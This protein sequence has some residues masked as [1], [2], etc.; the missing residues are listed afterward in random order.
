MK[1]PSL[2]TT[3]YSTYDF[4]R[5]GGGCPSIIINGATG[6]RKGSFFCL[7]ALSDTVFATGTVNSKDVGVPN[8]A[9]M[10]SDGYAG[11]TVKAGVYVF[12]DFSAV[13]LTS[14]AVQAFTDSDET[15]GLA[16]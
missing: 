14:G 4:G 11:L 3:P 9:N 6:L 15:I 2:N 10:A 12:G 8:S 7:L 5:P 16:Q 1:R 13:I